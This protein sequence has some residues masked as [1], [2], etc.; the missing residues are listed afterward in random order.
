MSAPSATRYLGLRV[1]V[2]VTLLVIISSWSSRHLGTALPG[3]ALVGVGLLKKFYDFVGGAEKEVHENRL[4]SVA[5]FLLGDAF[6]AIFCLVTL[7]GC[8][9]ISSVT[10]MSA[11]VPAVAEVR[12]APEGQMLP[13]DPSG[14]LD[15]PASLERIIC[16]TSPLGRPYYLEVDGY[17]RYGFDLPAWSGAQV[18]L[19]EDLKRLPVVVLRVPAMFIQNLGSCDVEIRAG[20]VGP[21]RIATQR[22]RGAL[23]LG[24]P[25]L[26]PAAL[27]AEWRSELRAK[28]I[29]DPLRETLLRFW[30]EPQ[31][32][33][34]VGTITPGTVVHAYLLNADGGRIAGASFVVTGD[35]IQ[36]VVLTAGGVP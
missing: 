25:L 34:E 20:D 30:R 35:E 19:S 3:L 18:R 36:D 6:L 5:L 10:V 32:I 8:A 27:L 9:F 14:Q 7:F 22:E 33:P 23:V 13:S 28:E 24:R 21:L 2:L 29:P 12:V 15:G 26:A 31:P 17:Q 4:R 16:L 11:G 1:V